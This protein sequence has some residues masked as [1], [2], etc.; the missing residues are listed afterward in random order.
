MNNIVSSEVSKPYLLRG[1]PLP[2]G[3]L[4]P[5]AFEDF[6]FCTLTEI[7]KENGF[8][9]ISGRQPSGDGGFDVTA[10]SVDG[11]HFICIQCKRYQ[12][13]LYVGTLAAELAKVALTTQLEG[14]IVK[15][16]QLITTGTVSSNLRSQLRQ[17][18]RQDIIDESISKLK[19]DSFKELIDKCESKGLE[20]EQIIKDYITSLNQIVVWSG[21]EFG[22]MLLSVWSKITDT[23]NRYFALEIA[24]REYP[25][26]DF[27]LES[28]IKEVRDD[29]PPSIELSLIESTLPHN[30]QKYSTDDVLSDNTLQL[31]M[32][33]Q[34]FKTN[35]VI[36]STPM[37]QCRVLTGHGGGGKSTTLKYAQKVII[38]SQEEDIQLIPIY[39]RLS[40]YRGD[41][42][43]LIHQK[44]NIIHGHWASLP[45]HF[46]LLLDGV[47]EVPNFDTQAL[48]DELTIL[49]KRLEIKSVVSL[50]ET[51]LRLLSNFECIES[52][53]N[54]QA[55][56]Y[57]DCFDIAEKFL[58]ED[59]IEGF[60]H[61]FR[62]KARTFASE[63][64]SLPFG[65][66]VAISYYKK[67]KL[68]P[69]SLDEILHDI[70]ESRIKHNQTR[71][72]DTDKAINKVSENTVRKLAE[73]VSFEFR[74]VRQKTVVSKGEGESIVASALQHIRNEKVFGANDLSDEKAFDI[75]I[76]YEVL[77]ISSDNML[78]IDHD[79]IA[80]YLAS[81]L[82]AKH[83]RSYTNQLTST[84]N[85]DVWVF[86]AKKILEEDK[87]SF[88]DELILADVVL[89]SHCAK[90]MG[91][92]YY[93]QVER[94]IFLDYESDLLIK[95][96]EAATAMSVLS[97]SNC[98]QLLNKNL[99]GSNR[100]R[101]YQAQRA[102]AVA[103]DVNFLESCLEGNERMKAGN[104]GISGGTHDMWFLAPPM[105]ATDIARNNILKSLKDDTK[106]VSMALETIE[107]YGDK[108]DID[109]VTS[110]INGT[111][112]AV[113][114]Y[115]AARC[116]HALDRKEAI[117]VLNNII[118]SRDIEPI[119]ICAM[120]FMHMHGEKLDVTRLFHYYIKLNE[121]NPEQFELAK[122]IVKLLNNYPLP[123]G[124]GSSLVA[125]LDQASDM[126]FHN[127]W[128][129]A[130]AHKFKSFYALAWKAMTSDNMRDYSAATNFG[131]ECFTIGKDRE[132][133]VSLCKGKVEKIRSEKQSTWTILGIL[134]ALI[135][136]SEHKVVADIISQILIEYLPQYFEAM[137]HE[138]QGIKRPQE[139]TDLYK[140]LEIDLVQFLKYAAKV[141]GFLSPE[142]LLTVVGMN[143]SSSEDDIKNAYVELLS[144]IPSDKLDS[145]IKNI[146]DPCFKIATLGS[147]SSFNQTD[148]RREMVIE[149]IPTMLTHHFHN[150][151]LINLANAYWSPLFAS[152]LI[153]EVSKF[154]WDRM[155]SQMFDTVFPEIAKLITEDDDKNYIL[156]ILESI[157][158][159]EAK[160]ILS[161]WSDYNRIKR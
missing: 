48:F 9:I 2:L 126:Q 146:K 64:L 145:K 114:F 15:V 87:E 31:P 103:G 112:N 71:V 22:N 23:V 118:K 161:F 140:F 16:H 123:K 63:V 77:R 107:S 33:H 89:A 84:P 43:E 62:K 24:L 151:D 155:S 153:D 83:W 111:T 97:S 105:V 152:T 82:L 39:L 160:Q 65:L 79:I 138:S 133:F 35:E 121:V 119:T 26:P 117:S 141:K 128:G 144:L 53:Y 125:A 25:R 124:A 113:E 159:I 49:N 132:K 19:N 102:L 20:P 45:Y 92:T 80:D 57:R 158:N 120:N 8:R 12:G 135:K 134:E 14:S 17:Q 6:S 116:L 36:L 11:S 108:S 142:T 37:N 5:D 4:S 27:N 90:V 129:V 95:M 76:H 44:L 32:S 139:N 40:R 47:D 149:M 59:D 81:D 91:I 1:K 51:G 148:M 30:L 60:L 85:Q 61:V 131:S 54:L 52:C 154:P 96:A 156:P 115:A 3:E 99:T 109:N 106:F 29:M 56:S 143:I 100:H 147:I 70:L 122:L 50:R 110:V 137:E 69:N 75:V 18:S 41:L 104:I 38:G 130:T 94:Q 68:L 98:I 55:L 74:V 157:T 34:R 127:I 88:L 66:C 150:N 42:D 93:P 86:A 21:V 28:Y 46:F 73:A 72:H 58:A 101:W 13:T 10:E 7:G 78:Y 67:H 136:L